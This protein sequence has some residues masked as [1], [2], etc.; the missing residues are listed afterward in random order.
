[1]ICKPLLPL[2]TEAG[3]DV[4]RKTSLW[5]YSA[6]SPVERRNRVIRALNAALVAPSSQYK[7]RCRA[8]INVYRLDGAEFF[9]QFNWVIKHA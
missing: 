9:I 7:K 1:M 5:T 8:A 6:A 3:K 2:K 4:K